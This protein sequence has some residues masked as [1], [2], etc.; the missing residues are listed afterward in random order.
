MFQ[1]VAVGLRRRGFD[2]LTTVDAGNGGATDAD[3]LAYAVHE[4]RCLFTFNR[5]DF[6]NLHSQ[7]LADGRHH[8][9]ILLS[10]QV[11]LGVA[12]KSL[13]RLLAGRTSEDLR[14]QLFWLAI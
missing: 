10:P 11:P 2:V 12:V 5:G 7:Y 14:D 6:A 4:G 8:A 9:G 13:A 1:G 3:Q